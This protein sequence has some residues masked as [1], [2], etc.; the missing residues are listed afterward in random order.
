M[1]EKFSMKKLAKE[2]IRLGNENPDFVYVDQDGFEFGDDCGYAGRACGTTEGQACIVGQALMNLGVPEDYLKD[3]VENFNIVVE[4]GV[5]DPYIKK[6]KAKKNSR[7]VD[8]IS[9]VQFRQDMAFSWGQ[10][11]DV[12]DSEEFYD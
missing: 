6:A 7:Y 3:L 9:E 5:F 1:S 8:L 12:F 2:I 4:K 11:I 10:A